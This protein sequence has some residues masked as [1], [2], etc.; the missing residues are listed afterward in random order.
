MAL[1][2]LGGCIGSSSAGNTAQPPLA[3]LG[4]ADSIGIT[5]QSYTT[6]NEPGQVASEIIR[7]NGSRAGYILGHGNIIPGSE[8]VCVGVR[9]T[10]RNVDYTIDYSSGSLYFAEPI[11]TTES[12]KVDYR[13]AQKGETERVV[14]GQGG[15][16][17]VFG[18]GLKT[19]LTY[20]Y[21]AADG[22]VPGMSDILTYGLN[23]TAYFG[24]S[25][26]ISSLL[27]I[28]APQAADRISLYSPTLATRTKQSKQAIEKD[29][30]IVQD[31]DFAV[32]SSA[33]LKIS[34][35]DV[36]ENFA[37]FTTLRET[38]AVAN[39]ILSDL[40]REKGIKRAGASAQILTGSNSSLS[41][42][43][44][45]ITDKADAINTRFWG[46]E[47]S[48]FK[49]EM[50]NREVG[51]QFTR[52]KDLREAERMQLA[53]EAGIER[54][55]YGMS[56]V[57]G[58]N[59]A[60]EKLWSSIKFVQLEGQTGELTY[61]SADINLGSIKLHAEA[62]DSDPSFNAM[63]AMSDE[64]RT[65]IAL[66]VRRHFDPSAQATQV[67]AEDKALIAREVGLDRRNLGFEWTG[68]PGKA[69]LRL[70]KIESETGGLVRRDL[71]FEGKGYSV[72]FATQSIDK[73]F[74]RF[75]QMQTI[76][77]VKYG[78]ESGMSRH[79]AGG[80]FKLSFGEMKVAHAR[81]RDQLGA[82]LTRDSIRFKSPKLSVDANFQ[83]ID[84]EFS[85]IMDLAD[86][87]KTALAKE[88][89][90]SRYDY[91]VK[92][93]ASKAL[94]FDTYLYH[95]TN[96]TAEQ[97]RSQERHLVTYSPASGPQ[98]TVLSDNYSYFSEGGTLAGYSRRRVTLDNKFSIVGGLV[99]KS[100]H[101]VN[102]QMT[103]DAQVVKTEIVQT[104]FETNQ[105]AQTSYTFDTLTKNFGENGRFED[106][107]AL[108]L[109][110]QLAKNL[111]ITGGYSRT[112][113]EA[114]NS[115]VNSR[116]GLDWQIRDDLSL[117][118]GM[119]NR[120]GGPQGS[121]QSTQF[122]AKG[123]LA[124]RLLGFE[125]VKINSGM[126]ETQLRGTQI[127]CDNSLK[128]DARFLGGTVAFDNS[129]KL[130]PKTGIYY[131]SRI[132]QYKS[133][134]NPARRYH[135][136]L[137]KQNLI[138]T[139]GAPAQKRNMALDFTLK[140][141]AKLTLNSYF[142]KDG[143]NGMVL[144]VGGTVI[145][146]TRSI[147]PGMNFAA[148]FTSSSNELT[149]RRARILGLGLAGTLSNSA[150]FEFYIGW[151]RLFENSVLD[152]EKIFRIKYE[153]RI[154][155]N[156]YISLTAQKKSAVD[157]SSINPL[158]GTTV[159]QLDFKTVFD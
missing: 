40:E 33:K 116:L 3:W 130:N 71:N 92:F 149:V 1:F 97:T 12:I 129:D 99:F 62:R 5:S 105:G 51:K 131:T 47:S 145:K 45:R 120:D 68:A 83:S 81:V 158:E 95:S 39:D 139:S 136:S 50:L 123:V 44:G 111:K 69:W 144:P 77:R 29:H 9:R 128:I 124:K 74:D 37:G 52:F 125:N 60:N 101:D 64:E 102:T 78:K 159:A 80:T 73:G 6:A 46:Y 66:S 146:F 93:Q 22:S 34:F 58:S 98:V 127:A 21:R 59:G 24:G 140:P 76:E 108:G 20:V 91:A 19:N 10:V 31:A 121:Q 49:F 16:P 57:S 41:F 157:K 133:D 141:D 63:S 55:Q 88:R 61:K 25:S 53:A 150:Q 85:R 28:S 38:K 87:D 72:Y 4:I 96:P 86:L 114:D 48:S 138:T 137:F 13:Y 32:G 147:G 2:I 154:D 54:T 134:P 142:G 156:R 84:P 103:E 26:T 109:K 115:E 89:G 7:G 135:L 113:R 155:A 75:A 8:W 107:W 35:Q 132:L 67:P 17:L 118:F 27:Y 42:A 18:G 119:A 65:Q 36:G 126:N 79:E 152:H 30:I 151:C 106:T 15:M 43:L 104:H 70:S 100:M 153:H 56:F 112:A 148:D 94:N 82:T 117:V 11:R 122:I 14:D 90:F 23:T 110:T 143:Q